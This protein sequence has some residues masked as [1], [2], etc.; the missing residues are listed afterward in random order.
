MKLFGL[1]AFAATSSLA[2][3]QDTCSQQLTDA[4]AECQ[5]SAGIDDLKLFIPAIKD[6]A[7]RDNYCG[8]AWAGCAKLKLLAPASDCIFWIWKGWSVNPSKELACPADQT[9]MLCTPNRLAVSEGYGLL[10]A[11]TIQSNTNEQ[12]AYNNETKAIVAKSNGQCLDVYKDNNQFK[13]HTYACDSKNTNQKWTITNHKVQHA[14]HGVCLQADLGHPGAA[15]GV[16]PCSGASETN[17]WFDACDRVPKGYVQLRAATGKNLLEY[18]SGLYL[19]P[20]GHDF[21][22]IFEW[23]N[24]LLKSA[25]NGQCLDVYKDG[26]GQ[27]KLHT[28][29]CDSNNGNQKW[30]IANNVVKHATHNNICLDADPTYADSHAQVWEC[31]PNN[32]NQQW[33]LLQYSK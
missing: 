1:V 14:V 16:A 30:T 21:N 27:F 19:N 22:D 17:Q 32:P 9:T 26:N 20:G 24:G 23:G 33:T 12:F 3:F 10:Y 25:S 29:A 13:L 31:T 15:V 28:Y 5:K 4:V 6:G 8:N 7:G 18:N 2:Q 11:N